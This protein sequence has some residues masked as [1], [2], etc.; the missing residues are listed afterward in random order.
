MLA[1]PIQFSKVIY[2]HCSNPGGQ[3]GF[4][5]APQNNREA[6]G[7]LGDVRKKMQK[8]A[9][10]VSTQDKGS[11]G[12]SDEPEQRMV[13][14]IGPLFEQKLIQD[15]LNSEDMDEDTISEMQAVFDYYVPSIPNCGELVFTCDN[16]NVLKEK[17]NGIHTPKEQ[18]KFVDLFFEMAIIVQVK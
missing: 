15:R 8:K 6:K 4:R 9:R 16:V 18:K 2:I 17:F 12:G 7:I 5:R 3:K 14:L 10:P 13:N 1:T 11:K